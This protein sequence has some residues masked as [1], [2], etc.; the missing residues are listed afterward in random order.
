MKEQ[1]MND[2]DP[3]QG[4]T[5]PASLEREALN[6]E[7][8]GRSAPRGAR[9]FLWLTI[10]VAIAVAIGVL[11]KA[12]SREPAPASDSSLEADQSGITNRLQPPGVRRPPPPNPFPPPAPEPVPAPAYVLP[13]HTSA[14]P[15]PVD[16]VAQRRLASPLQAGGADG[17]SASGNQA[18]APNG[19]YSDAGPLA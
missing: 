18:N 11:L 12:W 17:G 19:P 3:H 1:P 13:P 4:Q 2:T 16:E 5:T 10:L 9:A 15:P 6:L 8:A 14:A 7:T